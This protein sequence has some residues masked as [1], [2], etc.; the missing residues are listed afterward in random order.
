MTFKRSQSMLLSLLAVALLLNSAA[1]DRPSSPDLLPEATLV[2]VRVPDVAEMKE[3]FGETAA[4]AIARN[5]KINA[6]GQQ[7]YGSA[8][9]AFGPVKE[10]VGVSLDELLAVPKG[11][12]C[13]SLV[14]LEEGPPV[15]VVIMDVGDD[16]RAADTLVERGVAMLDNV[17]ATRS[18]ETIGDTR[19]IVYTDPDNHQRNIVHFKRDGTYVVTTSEDVA[20]SI[21]ARWDD[22]ADEEDETLSDNRRYTTIMNRCRG[23]KD[24]R[25]H[26][27]WFA[28]PIELAKV[29]TR[30]NTGAQI[31]LAILP[32]LGIDGIQGFGGSFIYAPEDFDAI[33]HAHLLLDSP[34][35][36]VIELVTFGNGD[37]SPESWVPT[38]T[39]SYTTF[40]YD[41]EK[42][43][44][45]VQ[46]LFDSFN[47]DDAL[48]D[49]LK[50]RV[51]DRVGVDLMEDIIGQLDGRVSI[52][53]WFEPP[54]RINSQ[55]NLVALKLKDEDAARKT[56]EKLLEQVPEDRIEEVTHGGVTFFTG[57]PRQRRERPDAE[58]RI[59]FRRPQ[60]C[61]AIVD[62]Y[63]MLTGSR[64]FLEHV[65]NSRSDANVTLANEDDFETVE[66]RIKRHLAGE[67]PS[68]V[69]FNRPN[70]GLK[71][72]YDV[73]TAE[74][75][76]ERMTLWSEDN[77]FIRTV[78]TALNDNPLPDY[79]EISRFIAP[80]GGII[81][82]D[83][84][85]IHYIG[86]ALK[87]DYED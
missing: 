59:E 32:A 71:L 82:D 9:E 21:L 34:R 12:L 58:R 24:E 76:R 61:V 36:G 30:G 1:A 66:T 50:R 2:C 6:L 43:F 75:T 31:G 41:F 46:S 45:K 87:G 70:K 3:R 84:T 26:V 83:D 51:N 15:L 62:D 39:Y 60:P 79:E 22:K 64:N 77:P 16:S 13:V 56:M 74:S 23:T 20:K 17:G 19:V 73:V 18:A 4:G 78:N 14:A 40:H 33:I 8:V 27:T 38:D 10:R 55:V 47:G 29:A 5:E 69:H 67:R 25:P 35:A 85:G 53:S 72:I 81:T 52:V 68:L 42:S 11:E 48:K 37:T 44:N 65:I 57:T 86:F 54:A 7:L 80:G 49:I 63:L 28:N